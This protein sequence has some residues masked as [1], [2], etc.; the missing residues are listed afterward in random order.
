MGASCLGISKRPQGLKPAIICASRGAARSRA[1]SKPSQTALSKPSQTALS[2]PSQAEALSKAKSSQ[3]QSRRFELRCGC[4]A[5][6][7]FQLPSMRNA[8]GGG[9]PGST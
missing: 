3:G 4:K 9:H 8:P 2:K 7:G 1:L 6:G 5:V